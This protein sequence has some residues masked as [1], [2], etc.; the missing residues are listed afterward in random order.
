MV[1]LVGLAVGLAVVVAHGVFR[2]TND[3]V[4]DEEEGGGCGDRVVV[5]LK[6]TASASY[7]LSL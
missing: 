3:L 2:R 4:F 7:S 1:F 6:E 5:D